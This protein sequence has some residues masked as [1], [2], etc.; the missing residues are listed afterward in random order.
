M[1][2]VFR[3]A[4]EELLSRRVA[5]TKA[6]RLDEQYRPNNLEDALKIQ[7]SMIDLKSDKVGGWKCLLPL[8][9]DKFIVAPIFSGSVQQGEVCELFADN[10]VVRVEPEI[11][12]TLAKSLPANQEGY[13]E[14]QVNDAIGSC[15]MALEL[16]QSRFADDSGAEFYEKLTDGLVNQGLFIGPEIDREKAF[17][18]AEINIEVTQGEQVQAFAGKHPNTLPPSPI[19]WLINYMTRRG[20]DFQAGE[21]I[22][23]GSY[24]GVV[25]MGFDKPTTF[26][27]EGIGE[28][29]VTFK[30]KL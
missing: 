8:A 19:Y 5:G 16:M 28:Y 3:Q 18:S 17:T 23:T 25:E 6:P 13:S 10:D 20:V 7:S 2:N 26:H 1:T 21:A 29:Q 24:C 12:F 9:G 30:Q 27:Y 4:A 14:A 11:A 15:H 22:I